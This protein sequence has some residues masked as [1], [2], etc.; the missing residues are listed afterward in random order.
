MI[1]IYF[2]LKIIHI[3]SACVLFG[4]GMGTAFYMLLANR[5]NSIAIIAIATGHVVKADW[6]FTTSSGIIQAL[7]GFAMVHLL[8]FSL[9]TPWLLW[10]IIGYCIAGACWL[11]VVYLQIQL[12]K[13]AKESYLQQQSLPAKYYLYY[14]YWFI[15]GW[16]AFIALI[17]VYYLMVAMP[18]L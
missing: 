9:L 17:M 11:P 15:L 12:H 10:A 5:S 13:I 3:I 16:P 1:Q 4:T 7:T 6:I 18:V 8:G 2:I 14:R